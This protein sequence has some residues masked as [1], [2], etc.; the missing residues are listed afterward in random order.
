MGRAHALRFDS[1]NWARIVVRRNG[2]RNAVRRAKL[3][4]ELTEIEAGIVMTDRQ[5]DVGM[6]APVV[7]CLQQGDMSTLLPF[8]KDWMSQGQP[9]DLRLGVI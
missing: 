9:V 2:G 3:L 7:I 5:T 1:C 4:E 6:E 8:W